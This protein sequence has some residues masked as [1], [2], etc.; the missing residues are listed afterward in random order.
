MDSV[1]GSA[2]TRRAPVVPLRP[3]L[4]QADAAFPQAAPADATPTLNPA[5][6]LGGSF[7]HR[8]TQQEGVPHGRAGGLH[9]LRLEV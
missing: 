2:G 1:T 7:V 5:N 9:G 8:R 3:V 6:D 4:R